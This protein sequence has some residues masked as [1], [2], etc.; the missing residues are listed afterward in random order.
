MKAI[1]AL[2]MMISFPAVVAATPRQRVVRQ[3]SALVVVPFAVPVA[4]PVAVVNPTGV[5]YAYSP[6]AAAYDAASDE[7]WREFNEFRRWRQSQP[8]IS[9]A[10]PA[11]AN[12]CLKCH[13]G[14][15]AK[16]EFR[17]DQPLTAEA[18]IKAIR[19]VLAGQMPKDKPL[20]PGEI[21][22]LIAELATQPGQR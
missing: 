20:S 12:A 5:F 11:V 10:A 15:A 22:G 14:A 3:E 13:A 4:T 6:Q 18:R 9:N 2:V 21:S 17:L 19:A 8:T 7:D 16:G 1:L